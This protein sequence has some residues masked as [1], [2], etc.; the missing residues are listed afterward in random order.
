MSKS[1]HSLL[2]NFIL[3]AIAQIL[4]KG[5]RYV[6]ATLVIIRLG[7]AAWGQVSYALTVVTYLLF[8]IDFGLAPLSTTHKPNSAIQDR[9]FFH[10][11]VPWRLVLSVVVAAG[12]AAF[13]WGQSSINAVMLIYLLALPLRSLAMEW[14]FQRKGLHGKYQM[15]SIARQALLT[16]LL[17]AGLIDSV[18]SFAWYDMV[19]EALIAGLAWIFGPPLNSQQTQAPAAPKLWLQTVLKP[20]SLLFVS[21]FFIMI[22]QNV[23]IILLQKL[24]D[25]SQVGIYDYSA[26]I[27]LA[28]IMLGS[29]FSIPLRRKMGLMQGANPGQIAPLL[30]HVQGALLV[31]SLLFGAFSLFAAPYLFAQLMPGASGQL[32]AQVLAVLSVYVG[33][34]FLSIPLSEWLFAQTNKWPYLGMAILAGSVNIALNLAL[35]PRW[36]VVGS[37]W[38]TVGAELSIFMYLGGWSQRKLRYRST[39]PAV[40]VG[41]GLGAM[42][43]A[44]AQQIHLLWVSCGLLLYVLLLAKIQVFNLQVLRHLRHN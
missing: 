41:L 34:A 29:G 27:V 39:L 33:V 25:F 43:W 8:V 38:A 3:T 20:A 30:A 11:L 24:T 10:F 23:A 7:E 22:H 16:V 31:L 26:K 19:G 6:V 14:W 35:I 12:A 9:Y 21:T 42:W 4:G 36:G 28:V 17:G 18:A 13:L 15:L 1:S 2:L 32:A 40:L 44:Q 5:L 37:A